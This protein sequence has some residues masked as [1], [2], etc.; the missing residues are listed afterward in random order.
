VKWDLESEFRS[1]RAA[2]S[3]RLAT[4][5][6]IR[7]VS[8]AHTIVRV[9]FV[10]Q[11]IHTYTTTVKSSVKSLCRALHRTAGLDYLLIL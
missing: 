2:A 3:K 11:V 7:G 8:R 10:F 5:I 9:Y 6:Y 1:F 4:E